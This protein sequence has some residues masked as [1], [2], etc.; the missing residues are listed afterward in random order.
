MLDSFCSSFSKAFKPHAKDNERYDTDKEKDDRKLSLDISKLLID[1]W[2]FSLKFA[3]KNNITNVDHQSTLKTTVDTL[4]AM[5]FFLIF[6]ALEMKRVVILSEGHNYEG[7]VHGKY[8]PFSIAQL[9]FIEMCHRNG[10]EVHFLIVKD[11]PPENGFSKA[12]VDGW[13]TLLTKISPDLMES[14]V[15]FSIME[16]NN[17]NWTVDTAHMVP[18]IGTTLCDEYMHKKEGGPTTG[19]K[20]LMEMDANKKFA[21]LDQP[22]DNDNA[23][24]IFARTVITDKLKLKKTAKKNADDADQP[25]D[26]TDKDVTDKDDA[27]KDDADK[28]DA[29]KNDAPK[30][31][32]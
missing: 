12:F 32:A 18:F 25:K 22:H 4:L 26:V 24:V 16:K 23:L 30:D 14:N 15:Y 29:L 9:K 10:C 13:K 19:Y 5:L 31:A 8:A 27:N 1:P 28:G 21:R 3:G 20:H 7:D 2:T 6:C 11:T 17:A